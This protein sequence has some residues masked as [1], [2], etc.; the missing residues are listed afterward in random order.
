[1]AD[2]GKVK[3]TEAF[4]SLQ[5]EGRYT[6]VPSVFFRTFGCNFTCGSFGMPRG[7]KSEERMR[8]TPDDFTN[9]AKMPL[10]TTGCDSYASW[11]PRFRHL[12]EE[13]TVD[14]AAER[15]LSLLPTDEFRDE[16]LVI[17]G[18]EPLLAVW[19]PF[20]KELLRHPRLETLKAVTFETNGSQSWDY[21]LEQFFTKW[22]DER[23]PESL[24][25][26]F[27]PKLPCSG[28]K[29]ENAIKPLNIK[30]GWRIAPTS[31]VKFVVATEEDFEDAVKAVDEFRDA[32]FDGDVYLMPVGG[33][34]D[35]YNLN[36]QTVAEK[37]MELGWRFSDRLQCSLWGNAWGT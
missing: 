16:H 6:G 9:L 31:Y 37:A 1:M 12:A 24:T 4:Y 33:V 20:W 5:G 13:L 36:K 34:T 11:D 35:L 14:E 27:S 10:V 8:S 22:R 25:F 28:E 7:E 21:K 29:W 26:S 23:G 18:G 15:I 19:H 32:G 30:K 2:A 17:T 3:L